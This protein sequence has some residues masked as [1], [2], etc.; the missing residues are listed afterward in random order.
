[1]TSCCKNT[2]FA[3]VIADVKAAYI[4]G[5]PSTNLATKAKNK[6]KIKKNHYIIIK[7]KK[8]KKIEKYCDKRYKPLFI[9]LPLYR[10]TI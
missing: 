7:K 9:G 5:Y 3:W 8:L 4:Q 1:L 2:S 6:K 10:K